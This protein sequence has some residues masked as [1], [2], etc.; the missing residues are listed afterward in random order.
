MNKLFICTCALFASV[1][2]CAQDI[3]ITNDAKKIDAKVLEISETE[4]KYKEAD[5][6][7]G[8][9]YILGISKVLSIVLSSGKVKTFG[10][11]Q[12]E[13]AQPVIQA[14][15]P[16][17]AEDYLNPAIYAY[18]DG[19]PK[20]VILVEGDYSMLYDKN[21]VVFFQF[22]YEHAEIVQYDHNDKHIKA[23]M[24]S[25]QEYRANHADDFVGF[26]ISHFEQLACE[27]FNSVMRSKKC[28]MVP[29]FQQFNS[30]TVKRYLLNFSVEKMDIGSGT[31]SVISVNNGTTSGGVIMSGKITLYDLNSK[32]KVCTLYADRV[33][34]PGSP[35][36]HARI[37]NTLEELVG[38]QLFFIK[39]VR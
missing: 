25:L 5:D 20:N 13:P 35:H 34:G 15:Q 37:V 27:K 12:P 1:L 21:A 31:A 6:L 3:I 4:I 32:E 26:D 7:E 14:Q 2:V 38:K 30:N 8:P 28:K 10:T 33:K 18:M 22:D 19:F 36:F 9:T 24:G 11:P 17:T 23:H 16:E 39:T 29:F